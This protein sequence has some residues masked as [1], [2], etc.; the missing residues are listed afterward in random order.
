MFRRTDAA[1]REKGSS[2]HQLPISA[3]KDGGPRGGPPRPKTSTM[4]MRRR[5]TTRRAMI[6]RGVRIGCI[7]CCRRIDLRYWG[8]HQLPGVRNVGFASGTGQQ[9]VVADAMEALRQN[10]EQEAPDKLVAGE[11]HCA[12]PGLTVAAVI[13][14]AEGHA[15][16]VES[17]EPAVRD[18]DTMGVAGEI[19]E[20]CFR[21]G[22]G[23]LG[24]DE[25]ILFL[26]RREMRG[27]SVAGRKCAISPK[28]ASRPAAWAPTSAA[29]KSRRNRRESTRTGSRK[30]GLQ[31]T[32]CM[33]LTAIPP[34]GTIIWTCGW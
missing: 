6:G 17:N 30:P 20:H 24:V 4:I 31:R 7:V 3:P 32:Q 29:R 25:P 10:V 14:V 13:L 18:G 5:S 19:G 1:V 12:V 27:E 21:P 26:E 2:S 33:P 11:R 15:A 34:P 28:N 22:E 9:P 23:R 16:L 8:G